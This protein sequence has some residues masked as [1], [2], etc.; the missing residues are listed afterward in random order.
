MSDLNS[1]C[2]AYN[3]NHTTREYEMVIGDL[4]VRSILSAYSEIKKHS[5]AES[6]SV[7]LSVSKNI[8]GMKSIRRVVEYTKNILIKDVFERKSVID[9]L[10]EDIGSNLKLRHRTSEE[11]KVGTTE[12]IQSDNPFISIKVRNKLR[13]GDWDYDFNIGIESSDIFV[14]SDVHTKSIVTDDYDDF[15]SYVESRDT[16]KMSIEIEYRG[17]DLSPDKIIE[18]KSILINGLVVEGGS[19]YDLHKV[20]RMIS[21]NFAKTKRIISLTDI[22]N[23]PIGLNKIKFDEI[24][25]SI[26]SYYLSPK[27]DGE[28]CLIVLSEESY[29]LTMSG[30]SNIDYSQKHETLLDAEYYDN[31]FIIF[32]LLY[33]DGT[34][35]AYSLFEDRLKYLRELKLPNNFSI[36]IFDEVLNP[37]DVVNKYYSYLSLGLNTDGFILTPKH[38]NSEKPLTG[39]PIRYFD[40]KI[41]KWKP[42]ENMTI[43]FLVLNVPHNL[44]G[45]KPFI[46]INGKQMYVLCCASSMKDRVNFFLNDIFPEI[47]SDRKQIMFQ[48]S[49]RRQDLRKN[50]SVYYWNLLEKGSSNEDIVNTISEF[51]VDINGDMHFIKIREDKTSE[52][53]MGVQFGNNIRTAESIFFNALNPLTLDTIKD[54]KVEYFVHKKTNKHTAVKANNNIKNMLFATYIQS[55]GLTKVVDLC[56]GKGQ[57]LKRYHDCKVT[58]LIGIDSSLNALEEMNERKYSIIRYSPMKIVLIQADL[59]TTTVT[60]EEK[61]NVVVINFA[62]HYLV[63]NYETLNRLCRQMDDLTEKGYT[64][65]ITCFDGKSVLEA[66]DVND[67]FK[68]DKYYIKLIKRDTVCRIGVKHHFSNNIIEENLLDSEWLISGF[69]NNMFNLKSTKIFDSQGIDGEDKEYHNL[70]RYYV[71]EK[72]S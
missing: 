40:D 45:V 12:F 48:V 3:N 50:F 55:Q 67:E 53:K 24:S 57:D 26:S 36:Q 44:V 56:C 41:Y 47:R 15:V 6:K 17:S 58:T 19:V 39:V 16:H 13:V 35:F 5:P 38:I 33:D 65:I 20:A 29:V 30:A 59:N 46:P 7:I 62:I 22:I 21:N 8:L 32:D 43:D 49:I 70:Y 52:Y 11:V 2:F 61:G 28:R 54:E 18:A 23:K 25:S 14:I 60:N 34:H 69:K 4:R 9:T 1:L 37:S 31:K 72:K 10:V 64:I 71:F 51:K 66:L 42:P 68:R 27:L 63:H